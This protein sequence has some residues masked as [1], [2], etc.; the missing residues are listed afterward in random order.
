MQ[1]STREK[2][3]SE[4]VKNILRLWHEKPKTWRLF[5]FQ[6]PEV[7]F[8]NSFLSQKYIYVSYINR[9][10]R[11]VLHA[12][13]ILANKQTFKSPRPSRANNLEDGPDQNDGGGS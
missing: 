1:M 7:F 10:K 13:I 9:A 5:E 2:W 12:L 6:F 4:K 11:H 3:N 8:E